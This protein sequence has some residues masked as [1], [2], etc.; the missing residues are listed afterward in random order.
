MRFSYKLRINKQR[1]RPDGTAALFYQVIIETKKTT[2]PLNLYW[3]AEKFDDDKSAIMPRQR[4]DSL[5]NDYTL[6]IDRKGSQINEVFIWARLAQVPL[7]TEMFQRELANQQSR[8]DFLAYWE[9]KIEERY[10]K[11]LI[12]KA[13]RISQK[14]SLG[15]LKEY[16]QDL[17]FNQLT[18]QFLDEYKAWLFRHVGSGNTVWKKLKD[19]RTYV[20]TAVKDKYVF[21][22]PFK[23]FKMPATSGRID[24]LNEKEFL[25]QKAHFYS[26]ELDPKHETTLRAFL[27][28]CYTGLRISDLT[29]V[30]W[31]EVRR[32]TLVFKPFKR[33]RD[34]ME[35]IKLP[36]H[37]Q[38]LKLIPTKKGVLIP[39]VVEQSMNRTIKVIA[40]RLGIDNN[41]SFHW[42]R[43][44]FATR[45]LRH[46]GR[47]EVL[48][49]LL[50]HKK[51]DTTMIYVHVD[52]ER[53]RKEI[54][55]MPE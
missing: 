37:E 23:G 7:T 10:S 27:F 48:Q 38:A 22:Y 42:A 46:G 34:I 44:T 54:D 16:T 41:L 45:F 36:L 28:A 26:D 51:I 2:V 55:L 21:T 49:Q 31:K 29:T 25:A 24:Y 50:G 35:E 6:E 8:H 30:T 18:P 11:G 3:P 4:N 47:I 1:V 19:M 33:T 32:E 15:T 43:H 53:K 13:S 12:K 40:G 20:N 14:A 39:S 9:R 52:D 5:H 17:S